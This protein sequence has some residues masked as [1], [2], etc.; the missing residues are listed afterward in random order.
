MRRRESR[1]LGF[2][3]WNSIRINL[4]RP[5]LRRLRGRLLL[6]NRTK[7]KSNSCFQWSP[8]LELSSSPSYSWL[9]CMRGGRGGMSAST[10]SKPHR[11]PATS[12]WKTCSS[13]ARTSSWTSWI[14]GRSTGARR[15]GPSLLGEVRCL[16]VVRGPWIQ[17]PQ[18]PVTSKVLPADAS[19]R[20]LPQLEVPLHQGPLPIKP[21]PSRSTNWK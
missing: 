14:G 4:V 15:R 13:R 9:R 2:E 11:R 1:I 19:P 6:K 8:F 12:S 5:L 18:A 7:K 16:V 21:A 10:P 20:E 17:M 3:W